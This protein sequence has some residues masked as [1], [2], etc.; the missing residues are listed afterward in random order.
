MGAGPGRQEDWIFHLRKGVKFHDGTDFNADAV[1]WNLERTSTRTVAQFEPR[2]RRH[3]ARARAD[4]PRYKKI[5]DSTIEITTTSVASY[6]PW[7]VPYMPDRLAGPFE[8]AGQDWAEFAMLAGRHGAVQDHDVVPR[9]SVTLAERRLLGEGQA[10]QVVLFPMPEATTR[11]AALRSGQVD[12]IEVPPPDGIPDAQG[13]RLR[14]RHRQLSARLAWF[15]NIG[16]EQPAGRTCGC[17]GRSTTASTAGPGHAAER[18]RRAVGRLAQAQR[19]GVRQAREPLHIRSGEGQEAAGRGGLHR[20]E[21]GQLK[22]M[23]STS[24]SGQ[25][26]PLP[27]NESLQQNLKEAA[28]S[29]SR[30]RRWNGRCC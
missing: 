9:Q 27:M 11:L 23:I 12:W 17:A 14:D 10:R 16:Q 7:M 29:T 4:L 6:F 8:K 24:G 25:M 26:L 22:V 15:F 18:H 5:D 13:G 30:S 28:A 19:P 3:H 20:Q 2:R 1:I 21:A